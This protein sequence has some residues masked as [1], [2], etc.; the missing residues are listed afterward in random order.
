MHLVF[1]VAALVSVALPGFMAYAASGT[2]SGGS[3]D[4]EIEFDES[5]MIIEFINPATG[6]LQE[7]VDYAVSVTN[8][9][10]N[11]FGPIP[12][13]HTTPGRVNI[14]VTLAYGTN[15]ITID[16]SG[17]LFIPINE[18]T[19]VLQVDVGTTTIPDWVKTNVDWWV[20]GHLD[21]DTFLNAIQYLINS[22]I[23][24]VDNTSDKA[25]DDPVP[26]W[27]KDTAGWWVE[28]LVSDD[29][30]LNALGYL[31]DQGILSVGAETMDM[32]IVGGVDLSHASPI[33][34]DVDAPV[35]VIEFG[36]YQCPN[37]K[38]WFTESRP[39]LES[40]YIDTG[41]ASVYFVDFVFIG[42]DSNRAAA[43]SYCAQEQDMYWEYHDVL[44]ENQDGTNSGW[45]SSEN[46]AQFAANIG[47]D[48]KMYESCMAVDHQERVSFN[49]MQAAQNGISRTPSFIIVGPNGVEQ[50]S[51]NQPYAVLDN[52][53]KDILN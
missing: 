26:P 48:A 16:V 29:E 51:G 50:L 34:G 25:S 22:A 41:L 19:L 8:G 7:H 18:E 42:E 37:C 28:G 11:L 45:A 15:D 36:D 40:D 3:L 43:A 27:V 6:S 1:V 39:S 9:D 23:I 2:T 31:V 14:P 21:D 46:L 5:Y 52:I 4:V 38:H 20:Q 13:T 12:L 32:A 30:F 53:L 10:Q 33:L 44:Y 47:L 24:P 35:T 49:T 17:I